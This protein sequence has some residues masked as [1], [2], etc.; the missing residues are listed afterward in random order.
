[1]LLKVGAGAST[2]TLAVLLLHSGG[3]G[4]AP[5]VGDVA[6]ADAVLFG[7]SQQAFTG[8]VDRRA[9]DVLNKTPPRSGRPPSAAAAGKAG[10]K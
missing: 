4:F 3:A 8:L 9:N 10:A 5:A 6:L 1:M 7:I 2:A